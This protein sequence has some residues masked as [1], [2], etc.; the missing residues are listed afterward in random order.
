MMYTYTQEYGGQ[1]LHLVQEYSSGSV[2]RRALCGRTPSK[3]GNWRLT[4]NLPLG[5][6]CANCRRI[7]RSLHGY[8]YVPSLGISLHIG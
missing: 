6:S 8:E 1:K 4:I 7:Y 2:S 3:R 5:Q